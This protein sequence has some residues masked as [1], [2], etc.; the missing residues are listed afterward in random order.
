MRRDAAVR[1][2]AF[3]A[4]AA[5]HTALLLFARVP[6][7]TAPAPPE[8]PAA[9]RLLDFAEEA[10]APGPPERAAA[11]LP[12]TPPAAALPPPPSVPEAAAEPPPAAAETGEAPAGRDPAAPAPAAAPAGTGGGAAGSGAAPA[13]EEEYL[14]PDDVFVPPLLPLKK[15]RAA[16]VYPP[17]ARRAGIEGRVDLELWIDRRGEVRRVDILRETP[18]NRGFGEA[19]VRALRGIR[20]KPAEANGLP[21]A[22]RFRYPVNFVMVE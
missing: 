5:A 6:A 13:G 22:V 9:L 3:A 4:A 19:A 18:P 17:V 8:Q 14:S 11:P 21:A 2:L 15:I 20:G 1:L 7:G 10:P 12:A 16:L